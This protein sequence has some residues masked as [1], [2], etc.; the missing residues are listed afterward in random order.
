VPDIPET[1]RSKIL[2]QGPP[3]V[4]KTTVVGRLV[5]L[6]RMDGARIGGFLT[7][8]IREQ[9]RRVGFAV[10]DLNGA[11]AIIAHQNYVTGVQV[12]RFGVD[13]AAF[14]RVAL[15]ALTRA[16]DNGE[17]VIVDEVAR[18]ELA[19][20]EFTNLLEKMMTQTVPAVATVHI[21]DHPVTDALV[22]R[23]DVEV[24]QVTEDNREDLP[25]RLLARLARP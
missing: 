5:D 9:G 14:E 10:R 24:V 25:A 15:P 20:A 8:E 6:L 3:K 12:G 4:G 18:M 22:R 17:I 16:L 13:V 23:P 1:R 2:L 21:H 11:E 19:S 7:R